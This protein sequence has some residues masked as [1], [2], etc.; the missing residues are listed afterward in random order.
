[1]EDTYNLEEELNLLISTEVKLYHDR[2]DDL[3]LEHTDSAKP[4]IPAR[5]FP[6]SS[7]DS[8]VALTDFD[9]NEVG[10]IHTLA[11]LDNDSRL[12]LDAELERVY[13]TPKIMRVNGL[14]ETYHIPSWD[15]ET[16]RGPRVFEIRS[17]RRD[18][19]DLGSGRL[20]IQ[21]ADGNRYEIPNYHRLDAVSLALVESVV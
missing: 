12:A 13:Y 10:I 3:I 14:T 20:L 4:V 6:L 7:E 19:R 16:D 9:G 5:A 1:M 2:F 11:D 18:I 21:D 15:V 8:F 17:G